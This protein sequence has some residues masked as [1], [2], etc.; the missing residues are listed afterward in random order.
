ME[1]RA[2][3]RRLI[4]GVGSTLSL[5]L[6]AGCTTTDGR[7]A[8]T[9][10]PSPPSAA[11]TGTTTRPSSSATTTITTSPAVE[12]TTFSPASIK[13]QTASE[14]GSEIEVVVVAPPDT[15]FAA[16][17]TTPGVSCSIASTS[18]RDPVTYTIR[19]AE[20]GPKLFST[21]TSGD[22]DY[23]FEAALP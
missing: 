8:P 21:I 23:G 3:S 18:G 16:G 13:V 10:A 7:T 11:S 12:T 17:A 1:A 15:R 14:K 19:C 9:G 4:W 6:L 2:L 20:H 22:Y 5:T